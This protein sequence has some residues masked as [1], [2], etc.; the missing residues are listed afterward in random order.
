VRG[1][2]FQVSVWE[3][4][5]HIPAGQLRSYSQIATALGRPGAARAVAGA[6]ASNPIAYLIPCHRV[7]RSLG[8][9]GGYR[10]GDTRKRLIIGW[11]AAHAEQGSATGAPTRGPAGAPL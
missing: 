3:A 11:E 6:V 10:W 9:I 4:L 8:E 2:N 1:T 7:I 5:L